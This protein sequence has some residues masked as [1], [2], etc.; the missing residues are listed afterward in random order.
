LLHRGGSERGIPDHVADRV[1]V[2]V[3]GLEVLV[4]LE[5]AVGVRLD[6]DRLEADVVGVAVAAD[7]VEQ[8][9]GLEVAA[10]A[11]VAADVRRPAGLRLDPGVA[12]GVEDDDAEAA[13]LLGQDADDLAVE[14][15]EQEVAR[16]DQRDVEAEGGEDRGVFDA[17]HAGPEH[18]HRARHARQVQNRLGVEHGLA[19]ERHLC[20][21]ARTRAGGD[22]DEVAGEQVWLAT[23]RGGD[24]D[25]VLV[26]ETGVPLDDL[27]GVTAERLVDQ[28]ELALDDSSLAEREVRDGQLLADLVAD[29]VQ[30]VAGELVEEQRALA[31]RLRRDGPPVDPVAADHVGA[32][33]HGDPPA[34]P[35]RLDGGALARRTATENHDVK[36]RHRSPAL[37]IVAAVQ[38]SL[39]AE[40]GMPPSVLVEGTGNRGQGTGKSG[41]GRGKWGERREGMRLSRRDSPSL[42]PDP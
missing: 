11:G 21:A 5:Q 22:H 18:D 20:R 25:R 35:R 23:G 14:V 24:R 37:W 26:E 15:G 41:E 19:V 31:Q 29:A 10:G 27:D 2:R 4:H 16:V 32:L 42:T 17:D 39:S 33:D 28:L 1:D 7:A 34:R 9:V 13:Q 40:A 6:A 3:A 30:T 12:V 36:V 38:A 8:H